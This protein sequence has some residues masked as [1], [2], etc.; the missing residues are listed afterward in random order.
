MSHLRDQ[1]CRLAP[2]TPKDTDLLL[3]RSQREATHTPAPPPR[4]KTSDL[5]IVLER[6]RKCMLHPT[7]SHT[8]TSPPHTHS[9]LYPP[10][11]TPYPCVPIPT[12]YSPSW[13]HSP[14]S[15]S[16]R[17]G[18]P[19]PASSP[20]PHPSMTAAPSPINQ[21]RSHRE[22]RLP[23]CHPNKD[24]LQLLVSSDA[25]KVNPLGSLRGYQR[26]PQVV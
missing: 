21:G 23:E 11:L 13:L 15:A 26:S 10:L 12:P 19:S 17:G 4:E 25:C 14:A 2:L 20:S 24:W 8:L 16:A 7:Q 18:Q 22:I 1:T 9:Y 5:R 3:L 6:E